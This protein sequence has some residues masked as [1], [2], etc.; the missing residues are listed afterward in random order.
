MV[1]AIIVLMSALAAGVFALAVRA[2]FRA[3]R[4]LIRAVRVL[5]GVTLLAATVLYYFP[6][7]L[8]RLRALLNSGRD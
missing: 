5:L 3:L 4:W 7:L 8:D 6:D 1:I 2:L